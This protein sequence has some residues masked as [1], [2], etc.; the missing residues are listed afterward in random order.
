M[1]HRV[2]L[3]EGDGIGPEICATVKSVF[4]KAEV[5]VEWETLEAGLGSFEKCGEAITDACLKRLQ[6]NQIALKGP[7]TTPVG[8]GHRSIN[9]VIRK[10]LDLFVNV[11]PS[12]VIPGIETPFKDVDL[13]I[14]RENI[15]DTY[16]GIEY[17]QS[18]DSAV[19]L[20]VATKSGARRCHEFAFDLAKKLGRKKLAC[21]HKANIMKIT[22]GLWLDSFREV[23]AHHPEI[24]ASDIIVDNCCMQL[25]KRPSQFDMLVLPNLFGD[26]VS[27]LCA[28]LVGGLGV[29]AG[30]NIG[31]RTA[32]FEAVHG[33]APD[34]AGKGLANPTAVLFSAIS[35][36]RYM[37][38]KSHA[39]RIERALRT[40]LTDGQARTGDLGGKGNTKTFTNA[41]LAN[42]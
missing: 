29:A 3:I 33:S 10:A 15:E 11:R 7:T 6:E 22:D 20:R 36:L 18:E 12:F 26:I 8:S 25:V 16:G 28:G 39:D 2:S 37:E 32:I 34:I 19:G 30:A 14:V 13:I 27:D 5:P 9:V 40:A 17:R 31:K 42:L 35:M 38:L 21:V 4:L 24:E 23:A 1:K 41:I